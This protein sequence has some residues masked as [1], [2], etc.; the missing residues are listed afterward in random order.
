MAR[1]LIIVRIIV[2]S[3]SLL[4]NLDEGVAVVVMVDV[5]VKVGVWSL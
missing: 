2:T 3:L 4:V 1:Q 5:N